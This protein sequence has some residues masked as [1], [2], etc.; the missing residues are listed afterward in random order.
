MI[1]R[2]F[3]GGLCRLSL[4]RVVRRVV[5]FKLFDVIGS[6][7]KLSDDFQFSAERF[8]ERSERGDVH[9][10]TSFET[11]NLRLLFTQQFG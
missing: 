10:R 8:D 3:K 5:R 4:R 7:G 9:I 2:K 1:A 11:Q 6:V